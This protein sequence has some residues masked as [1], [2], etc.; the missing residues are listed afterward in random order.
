MLKPKDVAN[1]YW[2]AVKELSLRHHTMGISNIIG[3]PY[4]GNLA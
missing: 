3:L 2:A 1:E 4:Y